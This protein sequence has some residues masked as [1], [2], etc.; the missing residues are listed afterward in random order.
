MFRSGDFEDSFRTSGK[1]HASYYQK[2]IPTFQLMQSSSSLEVPK[3]DIDERSYYEYTVRNTPAVPITYDTI[4]DPENPNADWSG[5]VSKEQAKRHVEITHPSRSINFVQE[6][7]GIVARNE[8]QEWPR[9]RRGMGPLS[10]HSKGNIITGID[11]SDSERFKSNAQRQMM[12]EETTREQMVLSKRL[13]AKGGGG[14]IGSTNSLEN[15][16]SSQALNSAGSNEYQTMHGSALENEYVDS[17][18][19]LIGYRAPVKLASG[20]LLSSLGSSVL[21]GVKDVEYKPRV[22]PF[23]PSKD[24]IGQNYNPAPGYAGSNSRRTM[25]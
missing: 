18:M 9:R 2:P 17:S 10:E 1:R 19:S 3:K 24:L 7:G 12:F 5:L 25:L 20:S 21:A 11:V 4:Y 14:Q 16:G 13:G 15:D 23:Q 6:E 22:R 8:K